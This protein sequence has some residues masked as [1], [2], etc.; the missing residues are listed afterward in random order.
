MINAYVIVQ[1]EDP[2][3]P[4]SLGLLRKSVA[5]IRTL[6]VEE[7]GHTFKLEELA[8]GRFFVVRRKGE[9]IGCGAYVWRDEYVIELKHIYVEPLARGLGCGK[10]LLTHMEAIAVSDGVVRI[11]LETSLKQPAAIGL[12][13]AYGYHHCPP[14]TLCHTESVFMEKSL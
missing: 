4:E 8:A 13:V 3:E 9:A 10:A 2:H 5:F 11:V 7:A 1:E 6:Y 12:Y 14:Y